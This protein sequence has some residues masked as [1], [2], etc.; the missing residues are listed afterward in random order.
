[1]APS[2]GP[3]D[4]ADSKLHRLK[5][6]H[7]LEAWRSGVSKQLVPTTILQSNPGSSNPRKF[8]WASCTHG[9]ALQISTERAAADCTSPA[10]PEDSRER[11]RATSTERAAADCIS[12]RKSSF[13]GAGAGGW[14]WVLLG[15]TG[16]VLPVHAQNPARLVYGSATLV[17]SLRGTTEPLRHASNHPAQKPPP[18]PPDDAKPKSQEGCTD[19]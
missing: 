5:G 12:P 4:T 7:R 13:W 16:L 3:R 18:G 14:G 2:G 1:M 17:A 6:P 15:W 19:R 10:E 8:L 9:Y 11:P